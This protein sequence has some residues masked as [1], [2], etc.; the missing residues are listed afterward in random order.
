MSNAFRHTPIT[1]TTTTTQQS[2]PCFPTLSMSELSMSEQSHRVDSPSE[3]AV[4][5][6]SFKYAAVSSHACMCLSEMPQT[7]AAATAEI[8][9]TTHFFRITPIPTTTHDPPAPDKK[10]LWM[11]LR[12]SEKNR[13]MPR[14]T[15]NN[16]NQ[17]H[18]GT[19]NHTLTVGDSNAGSSTAVTAR[20]EPTIDYHTIFLCAASSV[21]LVTFLCIGF[22]GG[23]LSHARKKTRARSRILSL[24]QMSPQDFEGGR[25]SSSTSDAPHSIT[26]STPVLESRAFSQQQQWTGRTFTPSDRYFQKT[27]RPSPTTTTR[28]MN[29]LG[30]MPDCLRKSL[31]ENLHRLRAAGQHRELQDSNSFNSPIDDGLDTE[32]GQQRLPQIEEDSIPTSQLSA[33]SDFTLDIPYSGQTGS[34]GVTSKSTDTT[35]SDLKVGSSQTSR[36]ESSIYMGVL[37]Y[38]GDLAG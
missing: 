30:T 6:R 13:L 27:N 36:A 3:C 33:R 2:D 9:C 18:V 32:I 35:S 29:H 28:E 12:L 23:R 16:N 11:L 38:N 4:I 10:R 26:Y 20:Q 8:P 1:T 34:V 37:A 15:L 24:S 21:I 19:L 5:C 7:A 25:K 14:G 22:I 17:I 31:G